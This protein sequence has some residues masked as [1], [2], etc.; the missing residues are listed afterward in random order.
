MCQGPPFRIVD[1]TS[2]VK[3]P[4][5]KRPG[6]TGRDRGKR[7]RDTNRCFFSVMLPEGASQYVRGKYQIQKV[8]KQLQKANARTNESVPV[9]GGYKKI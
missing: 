5:Y 1:I 9:L 7:V 4:I 8:K 3:I 6:L 2:S